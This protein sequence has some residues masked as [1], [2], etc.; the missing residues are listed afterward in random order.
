MKTKAVLLLR[1]EVSYHHHCW[2]CL[3]E[4]YWKEIGAKLSDCQGFMLFE[5]HFHLDLPYI[6][7][8]D[9]E[10]TNQ[11]NYLNVTSPF[12]IGRTVCFP[13][14]SGSKCFTTQT[15]HNTCYEHQ[16]VPMNAQSFWIS[17]G[18][19]QKCQG[20][21]L[22]LSG[23]QTGMVKSLLKG[24]VIAVSTLLGRWMYTM[25]IEQSKWNHPIKLQLTKGQWF[26]AGYVL[27]ASEHVMKDT[28]SLS[29]DLQVSKAKLSWDICVFFPLMF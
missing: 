17:W 15:F 25:K 28:V 16:E 2:L 7:P 18:G 21:A 12:K 4:E 19:I 1:R 26:Q 5:W 24:R 8:T 20:F 13:L 29:S 6:K 3:P 10:R 11:S 22:S 23:R 14:V 27:T 9:M